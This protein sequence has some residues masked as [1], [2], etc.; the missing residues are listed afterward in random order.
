MVAALPGADASMPVTGTL[1][2]ASKNYVFGCAD[3]SL[4]QY[5]VT[6]NST[7]GHF[8]STEALRPRLRRC[9]PRVDQL[10][11]LAGPAPEIAGTEKPAQ[12]AGFDP[13]GVRPAH[14]NRRVVGVLA[15]AAIDLAGPQRRRLRLHVDQH[16]LAIVA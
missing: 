5:G 14:G 15:V 4:Q 11:R 7:A 12:R 2:V 1:D 16:H 13:K 3:A 6:E 9:L 10:L 8:I